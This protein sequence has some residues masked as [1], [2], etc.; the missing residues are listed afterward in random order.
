MSLVGVKIHYHSSVGVW[1]E[2]FFIVMACTP[3]VESDMPAI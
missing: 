2:C 1:A 3:A